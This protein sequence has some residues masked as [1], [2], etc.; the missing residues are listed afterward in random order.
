MSRS[1]C[2]FYL[3]G[4]LLGSGFYLGHGWVVTCVHVVEDHANDVEVVFSWPSDESVNNLKLPPPAEGKSRICVTF[5]HLDMVLILITSAYGAL[6]SQ[7]P[8]QDD[9]Y[10]ES[11]FESIPEIIIEFAPEL[12]CNGFVATSSGTK[13]CEVN[14]CEGE[15]SHSKDPALQTLA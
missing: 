6:I 3:D 7:F 12:P 5:N 9:R 13:V 10:S 1:I 14:I 11:I 4:D 8:N 15:F 2:Q